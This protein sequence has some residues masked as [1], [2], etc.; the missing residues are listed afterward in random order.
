MYRDSGMLTVLN[1]E[2]PDYLP[3]VLEFC[4]LVDR[5]KGRSALQAYRPSLELLRLSMKDGN[6]PHYGL[7]QSI[8]DTL[9]GVSPQTQEEVQKMAGYGPP[10]ETVGLNGYADHQ[11]LQQASAR[12]N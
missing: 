10:V 5:R 7:L 2:L 8:C 3:L 4:A 11:L 9:P 1:G 6:L 12:S